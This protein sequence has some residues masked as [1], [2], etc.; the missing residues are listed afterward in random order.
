MVFQCF[1]KYLFSKTK[2]DGKEKRKKR[3]AVPFL[4]RPIP[5][6]EK[7]GLAA[8]TRSGCGQWGKRADRGKQSTNVSA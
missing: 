3:G 8:D 7:E 6:P 1:T 2:G 5:A 4:T